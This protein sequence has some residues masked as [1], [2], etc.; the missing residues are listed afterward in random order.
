MLKEW[1]GNSNE[2][3]VKF[4]LNLKDN[5]PR[6]ENIILEMNKRLIDAIKEFNNNSSKQ[7]SYIIKLTWA[8]FFLGLIQLGFLLYSLFR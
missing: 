4:H 7:T 8:I 1:N 3:L 2:D 6:R 5:P